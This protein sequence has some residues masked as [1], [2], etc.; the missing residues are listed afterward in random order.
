MREKPQNMGTP[1]LYHGMAVVWHLTNVPQ[2]DTWK[3]DLGNFSAPGWTECAALDFINVFVIKYKS[4]WL[5][6]GR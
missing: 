1:Y 3:S 4:S 6:T 5:F 2:T